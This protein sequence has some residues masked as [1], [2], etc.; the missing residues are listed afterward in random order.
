MTDVSRRE[1]PSAVLI[2]EDERVSRR[3]LSMLLASSGYTT[4]AVGS[5]EEA[6][7]LLQTRNGSAPRVALIDLNLPG[8]SGIDLIGHLEQL[9]P[10]VYPVLV[11]AA[12]D[13]VLRSALTERPVAYLRKPLD[14]NQVLA[15][16]SRR[17]ETVH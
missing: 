6:L 16:I 15:V 11:T 8:M 9:D 14:F 1:P 7:R 13:D 5:A 4:E 12:A 10:S 3:A 17:D 2:V